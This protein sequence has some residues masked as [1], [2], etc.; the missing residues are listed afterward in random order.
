M[1]V[2]ISNQVWPR[3]SNRLTGLLR[4]AKASLLRTLRCWLTAALRETHSTAMESEK[5]TFLG[6]GFR[7]EY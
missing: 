4:M 6:F 1:V 7:R 2:G 5:P 3:E